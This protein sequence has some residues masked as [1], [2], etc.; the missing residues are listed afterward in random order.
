MTNILV[1]IL[2]ELSKPLPPPTPWE[3]FKSRAFDWALFVLVV[4]N[5]AVWVF[6]W[7]ALITLLV[8]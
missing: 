7:I 3:K 1:D 8:S 2:N 5:V 6:G 4:V